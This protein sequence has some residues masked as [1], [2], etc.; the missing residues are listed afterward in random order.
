VLELNRGNAAESTGLGT[1]VPRGAQRGPG[2]AGG[3][4]EPAELRS[5]Q[6]YLQRTAIQG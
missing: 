4:E 1:A 6:H 5:I 3:G 2:R